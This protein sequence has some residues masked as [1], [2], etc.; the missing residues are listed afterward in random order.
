MKPVKLVIWDLDNTLWKGALVEELANKMPI[1]RSEILE[2]IKIFD[3][4]GILQSVASKNDYDVAM[5]V[6]NEVGLDEYFLTPQINWNPK[7][8]NIRYLKDVL[9]L[10]TDT[11]AFIDDNERER[12][13]VRYNIPDVTT[14][15]PCNIQEIIDNERFVPKY[16]TDETPKRRQF[17]QQKLKRDNLKKKYLGSNDQF[18]ETLDIKMSI[19]RATKEDIDRAHE[20][21]V[22]TSQM[23]TTGLIFTHDEL[24]GL[25]DSPIYDVFVAQVSDKFGSSGTVGLALLKKN[26]ALSIELLVMSCRVQYANAGNILLSFLIQYAKKQ[27]KDINAIFKKTDRNRI[28]FLT[29]QMMGFNKVKELDE[30]IIL[31]KHQSEKSIVYPSYVKV[32]DIL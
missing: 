15:D 8:E 16:F 12:A 4:R 23:N 30:G 28:M 27:G 32:A 14:F 18:L 26:E 21:T 9:N 25:I 24:R 1:V 29:Y 13:E 10:S 22:R 5:K 3:K 2:A 31:L 6:L 11:F 17:Y 19:K 20:L 7:S